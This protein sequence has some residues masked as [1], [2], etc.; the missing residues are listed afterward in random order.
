MQNE[1]IDQVTNAGK[2]S[3]EAIQELGAI[4]A[5][6]LQKLTDLQFNL[7]SLN[8]ES[9]VEQAKLLSTTSNYKDLL[10]AE[11]DFA[12]EY[13]NKALDITRQTAEVLTESR[14]EIVTWLEKGFEKAGKTAK[15]AAKKTTR[16]SASTAS[17]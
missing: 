1:F 6:A 11:S 3:Y 14:D 10:S 9:G 2:T 17:S 8:L 16:K 5:R 13:S 4:Q 15:P 7:A 12:G